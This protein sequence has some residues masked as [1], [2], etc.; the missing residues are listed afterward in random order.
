MAGRRQRRRAEKAKRHAVA[1]R[2][3]PPRIDPEVWLHF[4]EASRVERLA[5]TRTQAAQALGVGRSTFDRTI[6]PL[7][8]TVVMPTGTLLVPVDELERFLTERR[9]RARCARIPAGRPGRKP[10]VPADVRARIQRERA[11]GHSLSEIAGGLNDDD[12]ATSQGGLKWW[13]STV[14]AVLTGP[15]PLEDSGGRH[16][17]ASASCSS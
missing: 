5:Y 2:L 10:G 6:L 17:T 15:R 11:A 16:E 7:I 12:V 1:S 9:Q 14:Q 3:E 8:E 13:P 4:R